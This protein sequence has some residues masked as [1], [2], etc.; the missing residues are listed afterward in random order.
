MEA[1]E[2]HVVIDG[3][4]EGVMAVVVFPPGRLVHPTTEGIP[5]LKVGRP[6]LLPYDVRDLAMGRADDDGDRRIVDGLP[7]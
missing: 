2:V 3:D 6:G 1:L 7:P 4:S 5:G